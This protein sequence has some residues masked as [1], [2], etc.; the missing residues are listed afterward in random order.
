MLDDGALDPGPDG[1]S[2]ELPHL[3]PQEGE[4]L[5]GMEQGGVSTLQKSWLGCRESAG[6]R[7]GCR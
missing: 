3:L 7:V 5:E 1:V 2:Q 6:S 4:R